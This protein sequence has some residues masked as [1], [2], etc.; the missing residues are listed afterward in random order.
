MPTRL[1]PVLVVLSVLGAAC[2]AGTTGPTAPARADVDLDDAARAAGA[3][4]AARAFVGAYADAPA[5]DGRALA[6]LVGT[7]LLRRWAGWLQVQ[8]AGF[9]G[10][11]AGD[12]GTVQ[13]GAAEPFEV[14]SVPGSGAILREVEVRASVTFAFTPSDGDP[15]TVVRSLDGPMRLIRDRD[16]DWSV[17]DFTRDAIPLSS[18]FETVA[19]ARSAGAV[20]TVV[21][22]AFFAAPTWQFGLVVHAGDDLRIGADDV[23]LVDEEGAVVAAAGALTTQLAQIPA[24]RTVRGL[25]AFDPRSSADGL[26]LR[27]TPHGSPGT[28][29]L[30]IPLSGRIHP[31]QLAGAPTG[32]S[33]AGGSTGPTGSSGATSGG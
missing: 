31:L 17:L 30:L 2:T 4:Q 12:A 29:A 14:D 25:A 3:R 26:S 33:G 28:A 6:D 13:I 21:L 27:L 18:Q 9:P 15:F 10:S 1:L 16:G 7:P 8:D 19:D 11:I 22:A 5:D 24:G 32:P 20:A 23:T